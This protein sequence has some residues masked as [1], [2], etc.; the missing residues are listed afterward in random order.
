LHKHRIV[1][2]LTCAAACSHSQA[3]SSDG[4]ALNVT[5]LQLLSVAAPLATGA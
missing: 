5:N 1:C 3:A 2:I 4:M